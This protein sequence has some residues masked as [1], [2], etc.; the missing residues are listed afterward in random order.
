MRH[1]ISCLG[2]ATRR[3]SL[4]AALA[5]LMPLLALA[6]GSDALR[7]VPLVRD[8]YVLVSFTLTKG[9]TD[10][11]RAAIRSG[12]K[13]TFTYEV[14]LRLDVPTWV[15]RTIGTATATSSVE[16][17]NLTRRYT[18]SRVLDGRT[19]EARITE[20]EGAVRQW[21]TVQQRLP[22]FRTSL[23][24]ANRDYYV[25]VQATARPSN[26]SVLWPFSAGTSAQTKFTFIR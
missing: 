26:G 17:D 9:F 14:E 21:L 20:D 11:V 2:T 23:L 19:E 13:T 15:D 22:L 24:Q 3:L 7:I 5:L 10:E 25:R 16:Y 6:Q 1:A 4:I 18:L 12:L 8:D